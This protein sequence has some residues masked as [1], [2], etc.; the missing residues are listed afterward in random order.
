MT[1]SP[2]TIAIFAICA[3]TVSACGPS[4]GVSWSNYTDLSLDA[5]AFSTAT[6][7]TPVGNLPPG[8]ASYSGFVNLGV[9]N[10]S[11][12]TGYLGNLD[13]DVN[14]AS[15]TFS[16]NASN[17]ASYGTFTSSTSSSG[18]TLASVSGDVDMSGTLSGTNN[19]IG[20]ALSGTTSGNID[21]NS[22]DGTVTGHFS[23]DNGEA[24]FMFFTGDALGVGVATD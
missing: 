9:S 20:D 2:R 17:F 21:G 7:F 13:V 8:S 24:M 1:L 6:P 19:N 18:P 23:G 16:G 14:F 15:Q 11:S 5:S 22:A 4:G 3:G 10:G 12:V